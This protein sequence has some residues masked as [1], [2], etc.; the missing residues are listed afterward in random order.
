MRKINKKISFLLLIPVF[1]VFNHCASNKDGYRHRNKANAVASSP[2]FALDK[3]ERNPNP[4]LKGFMHA[5]QPCVVETGNKEYPYMM[6]FFGWIESL[7]NPGYTGCDA[8]YVARSKDLDNWEVYC[9]DGTWDADEQNQKWQPVI[10]GDPDTKNKY[11]DS[12]HNGDPSVVLKDGVYYMAYS[13][14]SDI[15]PKTEG[16]PFSI[17]CCVMGATSKD[18]IHW[19]KTDK[20]LL[21]AAEDEI[22]PPKPYPNRIGDFH[23]PCLLWDKKQNKWNLYFDYIIVQAPDFVVGLAEN[24]GDFMKD[25]FEVVNELDEPLLR[26]WPNPEMVCF[27]SVYYSFSDGSGYNASAPSGKK[28]S[29]W[30]SR[31]IMV[32]KSNDGLKWEKLHT[33]PPDPGIDANQIPQT[34]VCKRDGK[35]WL[36][37]FYATQVGWRNNGVDYELFKEGEEYNWFYDQI[38]YMRQEITNPKHN[39]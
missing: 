10:Y 15:F 1:L 32:A 27:D 19:T 17:I 29:E 37:V 11:Y 36:Y 31:Q 14:T 33:I 9:K 25:K 26:N 12:Y 20:P 22:F 34:L 38:R 2:E 3:W 28:P 13:A 30:Q 21:M 23:R 35:W 24:K 16:Y 7:C 8:I 39:Y 4:V 18:G 5:Y 6:W